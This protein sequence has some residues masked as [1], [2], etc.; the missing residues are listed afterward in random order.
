LR[1]NVP[2][3]RTLARNPNFWIISLSHLLTHV[4]DLMN[5]ALIPVFTDEFGITLVQA[6]W[7]VTLPLL[8]SMA[9]SLLS[10]IVMSK[11]SLKPLMIVSL[12]LMGVA[13]LLISGTPN[14]L[15]LALYLSL[16]TFA[17]RLYCPPALSIVSE[18]CEDC[19]RNRGKTVGFHVSIVMLGIAFGPIGLGFI[20]LHADWRL[21]YLMWAIPL[22][23][24]AVPIARMNL[25][26]LMEREANEATE[27]EGKSLTITPI[28]T[29]GFILLLITLGFRSM[30]LQGISTFMTTYFVAEKGLSQSIAS[31]LFGAGRACGIIGVS[32]GGALSD[33]MGEKR[34]ITITWTASLLSLLAFSQAPSMPLLILFFVLY[35]IF[36]SGSIAPVM[37]LVASFTS[38]SRRGLGY[39]LYFFSSSIMGAF[40]PIVTAQ[41]ITGFGVG[42]IFPFVLIV[43]GAAILLIQRSG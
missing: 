20:T 14:F 41:I 39:M 15:M 24:S 40:S 13:A 6:G 9:S 2:F 8:A 10:G 36:N 19:E 1:I 7:L 22:F 28:V 23:V 25:D 34:W 29:T 33:T 37:S 17:S 16:L 18:S 12:S 30:G 42:Y 21:S 43:L 27:E 26:I 32:V 38:K 35:Q 11:F 3:Y 31:M 4:F 5:V